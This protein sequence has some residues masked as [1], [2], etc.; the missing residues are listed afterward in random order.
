ME[1]PPRLALG[2]S[3]LQTDTSLLML[4]VHGGEQ[5]NRS[6]DPF[7][8]PVRLANACGNLAALLSMA[9]S[10]GLAPTWNRLEDGRLICSATTARIGPSP[11][12]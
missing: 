4:W 1:Y 3:V 11:G 9:L 6:P 10:V 12:I 8:G 2:Y 5:S 7:R